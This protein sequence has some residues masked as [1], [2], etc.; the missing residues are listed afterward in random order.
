MPQAAALI[1]PHL[2]SLVDEYLRH[3]NDVAV[4]THNGLRRLSVT[5]GELAALA[6]RF[7]SALESQ[8]IG[9]GER[10]IVCGE[11]CAPWIAAFMGCVLRGV[12]VVPLD[13]A[14]TAAFAN[15]I[16]ADVLPRL[17][18]GS[19]VS[20]GLFTS[21]LPTIAFEE[22]DQR[23]P[24]QPL[25]TPEPG[26]NEN[27]PL[28]IVYTSGT[29]AEPKGVIHTHRNVLAS[30]RPIETE[31]Q[32]YLRYERF[33]HPLRFLHTLPLSHV[34]GQF[35][36]L[37]LPPLLGAALHF[38]PR[39]IAAELIETVKTERIS[40]IAAVPRMM[41]L[42]RAHL[43]GRFANVAARIER[44]RTLSVAKKWWLFRDIHAAFGFKFWAFVCGGAALSSDAEQFWLRLGFAVVQGYG[45]TET[46]A[47]VSLNHPF[48]SASGTIGK[49]MPGREIQLTGEG[50]ILVR[51]ETVAQSVWQNGKALPV[52]G[53][54]VATG[55][56]A[57]VDEQ[58]N[59]RFRGRK[60]EVIVTSAGLNIY[61]E[62]LEAELDRQPGIQASVVVASEGANGPEPVAAL[63]A[64]TDGAAAEAV[65][66]ANAALAEFQR[67]RRWVRWIEPDFPRTSNGKLLR[68]VVASR[69]SAAA[70][71]AGAG[72]ASD[73]LE[74]L[75]ARTT[76]G[77]PMPLGDATR[78]EDLFDSLGRLDFASSLEERFGLSLDEIE[79][80][81]LTT[82]ADLRARLN[83]SNV[84]NRAGQ[85]SLAESGTGAAPEPL[86]TA[87]PAIL[88][89]QTHL[90]PTWPWSFPQQAIRAAFLELIIRPFTWLLAAPRIVR[91]AE[92]RLETP[93]LIVANHVSAYDAPLVL[94]ALP[95]KMRRRVAVAMSA[96]ML[97]DFRKGRNL[98]NWFL[99]ALG[100]LTYFLMTG[101]F[102]IFP[103]PQRSS[104]AKS[105]RHAAAAMDRGYHVLVFPEGRR[106][107]DG[108]LA[109]FQ[110]G[111]GLL[112]HELRCPAL[113]VFISGLGAM[114]TGKQR[115][116][117]SGKLAVITGKP[118]R[119]P[120]TLS[121][122]ECTRL[123]EQSVAMLDLEPVG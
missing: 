70:S 71:D 105:F 43:I 56:L 34:F 58:G 18:V 37:W 72:P 32:K 117:R 89:G 75:V 95:A 16:A 76:H 100:P 112:W 73:T 36:G 23:L 52:S 40:V 35:M 90:Y 49:V 67:I 77:R 2:A 104:F 68:R 41:D 114:K 28:Q 110:K 5:Y 15:R 47:L 14:T 85:Q 6:G 7:A 97:L 79:W 44:A 69:L 102:N 118:L 24:P 1:R 8:R 92:L 93:A 88:S 64:A 13:A 99:N 96:E 60:K 3:K 30:V 54:W 87:M 50:E 98:G 108:A 9:K 107:D 91:Q 57:S 25:L 82:L 80:S 109:P 11:N 27:D 17:I 20:L 86:S 111:S 45:M 59:L 31:M 106:S 22:F 39:L 101:L 121:P 122:G 29:T 103:L 19:R 51:G 48:K 46:T 4:V 42:L 84:A 55:D 113:P 61:P 74:S 26:L 63:I 33:F 78:L 119:Y 66:S 123:L 62:D 120:E 94:Y 65:R 83:V 10:V 81:R 38:P 53:G 116:F 12:I 21:P 115:W